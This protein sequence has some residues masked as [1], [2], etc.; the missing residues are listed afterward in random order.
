MKNEI[1][2]SSLEVA[3]FPGGFAVKLKMK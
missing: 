1:S 2:S 3:L